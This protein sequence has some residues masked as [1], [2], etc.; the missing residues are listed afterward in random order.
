MNREL[1]ACVHAA[2]LPA[3]ALL[4]LRPE[5]RVQPVVVL[6][7]PA[8]QQ[9]VCALNQHAR[10]RGAALGMTRL[11]AE[12]LAEMKLLRRSIQ[13]EKVSRSILLECVS[14][15]SPRIEDAL[16]NTLW[17]EERQAG[18]AT[19]C[20]FVLDIQGTERLFGPPEQLAQRLRSGL[21]AAGFH[22]SIAVS[23]NFH[24][25]RLIAA[26]RG[27]IHVI[28]AG[29][30]A[31]MLAGLPLTALDGDAAADADLAEILAQWGIRNL[32]ELAALPEAELMT[33]LGAR[34]RTWSA[35][36]QGRAT[37]LFRPIQP[38]LRLEEFYAFETPVAQIDSLLFTIARMIDCLAQRAESRA[39]AL[40]TVTALM[41]LE[42]GSSHQ[43]A[44]RPALPSL[45]PASCSSSYRWRSERI[46]PRPRLL[47]CCSR[48]SLD[49][50][51]RCSLDSSPRRCLNLRGWTSLWRASSHSLEKTALAR[52]CWK[53][54]TGQTAFTC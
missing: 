6:D 42:D 22:A 2:E 40:A 48:P 23:A 25:A 32:G 8:A 52:P 18:Q 35:L 47:R 3:Q 30:E 24:S 45:D 34:A 9:T 17:D 19:A 38:A 21:S 37:H 43:R 4:R 46:R 7:G 11:D 50:A 20:A 5:W 53:T 31:A 1:Y 15:F 54:R 29:Q 12:S 26:H 36:A 27:G 28:A 10:R 16:W 39:L 14:Q 33:R 41:Q 51:V 44:I 49:R 13:A